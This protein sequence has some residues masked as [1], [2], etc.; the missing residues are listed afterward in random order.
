MKITRVEPILLSYEYQPQE[1]WGWSGGEVKVWH[2]SLVRV[3]TEEGI[4]G[5]GE[6][7]TGHYIPEAAKAICN[8]LAHTLIGQD[9]FEIN[10]L[11]DRMYKLG[12]NWGRRGI[13]MGVI[14]GIENALWDLK[15]KALGVPVSTLLGGKFRKSIRAYASGGMEQPNDSLIREVNSYLE[16]G[17]TAVKIRGGY[18]AKRDVEKVKAIRQ[19]LGYDFDLAIDCGQGYVPFAWSAKEAIR[20]VQSLEE[21]ELMFIEEP[22]RTDELDVYAR[23]RAASGMTPIAGGENGCSI[24]EY[25]ALIDHGCLDI[26]QPDVTHAGGLSEVKRA[27]DYAALQGITVAPHVFRSG[28]SF[29]A[30]LHLLS[31]IPNAL[32][33]EFQQVANPLREELLNQP[34]KMVNGEILIPEEPGLGI[35]LTD[36]IINKYPYKP[37]TEQRF[38]VEVSV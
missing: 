20:V 26:I 30:H 31:A 12:A 32:I 1:Q 18:N 9:P 21:Y 36:E 16:A 34:L 14:S 17:F 7:G 6:M 22:C 8:F 29:A 33:C 38:K 10:V 4:Y 28:A 3:W 35:H 5:L 24:Y 13:A 15:G 2:T 11:F 27:A 23:V 25:K 37:G 19:A